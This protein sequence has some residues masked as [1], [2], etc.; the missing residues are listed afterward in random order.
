MKQP[1]FS[2]LTLLA[3]LIAGILLSGVFSGPPW[4]NADRATDQIGR[5]QVSAWSAYSGERVYASG[6][7][8]IDTTNGKVID[9]AHENLG[10]DAKTVTGQ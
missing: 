10:I 1:R 6:Y 8:I 9:S 5:Y 2:L 4:A 7:Y 3:G